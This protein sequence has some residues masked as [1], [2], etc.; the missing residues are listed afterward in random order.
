M[1][2]NLKWIVRLSN[3]SQA[4]IC[5]NCTETKIKFYLLLFNRFTTFQFLES[6]DLL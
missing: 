2:K 3:I 4:V 1:R 6:G 5:C